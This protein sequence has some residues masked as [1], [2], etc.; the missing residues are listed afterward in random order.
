[1]QVT[2][3]TSPPTDNSL[4]VGVNAGLLVGQA[5]R[6]REERAL[7]IGQVLAQRTAFVGHG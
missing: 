4:T 3:L 2:C 6:H 1:M 7:V 5:V